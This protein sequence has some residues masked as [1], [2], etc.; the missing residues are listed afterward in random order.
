[1]LFR[2]F[3]TNYDEL[4]K[5]VSEILEKIELLE[6]KPIIELK[7][8][9]QNVEVEQIQAQIAPIETKSLR[10][11]WR[12]RGK[13]ETDAS[14]FLERPNAIDDE[15]FKLSINALGKEDKAEFAIRELLPPLTTNQTKEAL[16]VVLENFAK[17][18][19]KKND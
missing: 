13:D 7:I 12:I 17:F 14:I 8:Q 11:F 16:Q 3:K 9:G 15:L 18:K 10:C 6:K 2:S 19:E 5:E 1:M 4:G